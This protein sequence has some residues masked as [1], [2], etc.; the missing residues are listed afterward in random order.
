MSLS[1]ATAASA[2]T[3]IGMAYGGYFPLGGSLIREIGGINGAIVPY[4]VF[5]KWQTGALVM[6][7]RITHRF[8]SRFKVEAKAV[9][10]PG[11]VSTRD[12]TNRVVERSGFLALWSIRAPIV[13]TSP[14]ATF[15]VQV[16]PGVGV[17]KRGGN[18]WSGVAGTTD[19]TAVFAVSFGGLLGRRSKWS[20]RIEIEDHFSFSQFTAGRYTPTTRRSHHDMVFTLGVDYSFSRPDPI[21]GRR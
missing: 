13:V 17:A 19:P 6:S 12:S 9:H 18:A 20:S 15:Y 8:T 7:A 14:R 11:R 2:Q 1:L 21:S 10:S 4:P 5:E 16:A 3:S